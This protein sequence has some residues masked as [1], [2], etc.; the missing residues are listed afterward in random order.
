MLAALS[1]TLAGCRSS[2]TKEPAAAQGS[3]AERRYHLEGKVVSTDKA[4]QQIVVDHK[5]IPGFMGAMAMPYPV[6]DAAAVDQVGPGDEI[7]ADVVA[8]D[9][10]VHLEK[11]V[12]VKKGDGKAKS[13]ASQTL[14][15]QQGE[16]VPDFALLNQD[17]KR[18]TLHQYRG[19]AVLLSFIYTRCPLAEYC[20]LATHNL[21]QIEQT[22]AKDPKLYGRTHLLSVSFDPKYDTPAV[23]RNYARTFA[24]AKSK[25]NF[26]H[27]EFAAVPE[28]ELKDMA[29]FFNLFMT[30]QDGQI[31]HSMSTA[32]ISPD[33]TLYKWYHENDWKPDA[34]IADLTSSLPA[35]ATSAANSA[36]NSAAAAD[37]R[38]T[39]VA[40]HARNEAP[41]SLPRNA[42]ARAAQ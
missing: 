23:L 14:P 37:Q 38:T 4:Q 3:G 16:P 17:G 27:W 33:G 20:P 7:T 9:K 36:S 15:S 8:S 32:I 29:S 42:D 30:E 1:F 25:N 19:K 35:G 24:P 18:V 2:S 31:T 12:V 6:A 26:T 10:G 34:M 5:E 11:V 22:L 21:A 39:A 41:T 28:P 13:P 40:V